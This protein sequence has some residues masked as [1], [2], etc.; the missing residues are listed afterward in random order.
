MDPSPPKF[1]CV[2][3]C[4]KHKHARLLC[5]SLLPGVF[6]KF[7]SIEPVLLFN[8][9][10]LYFPL[11]LLSSVFPSI[12]VFFNELALQIRWT[13]YWNLS[14]SISPSN[15]H[16]GFPLGLTCFISL[17]SKRLSKIFSSTTVWNQFFCAQPSLWSRS[18]IHTWL[19]GKTQIWWYRP[20]TAKWCLSF[21]K[22]CLTLWWLFFQGASVF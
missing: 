8:H 20:L 13:K 2:C 14:F 7:I 9:F 21:L 19:L 18:H 15:V 12:R 4:V 1:P 17:L 11:L 10:N 16:S 6:F 22:C 3:V 5:P